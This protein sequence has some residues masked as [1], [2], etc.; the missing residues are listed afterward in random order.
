ME[1]GLLMLI[2]AVLGGGVCGGLLNSWGVRRMAFRLDARV[3]DL[4]TMMLGE[5]KKRA[6]LEGVKA[7]SLKQRQMEMV[8][9]LQLDKLP[10]QNSAPTLEYV[11][12]W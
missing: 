1:L 12:H 2:A 3:S 4:E 8:Q 7:K 9:E 5:I 10:A 6:G 11:R